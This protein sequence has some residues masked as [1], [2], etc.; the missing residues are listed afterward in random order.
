MC[1]LVSYSYSFVIKRSRILNINSCN[2]L[3]YKL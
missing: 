1:K 2:V 3:D